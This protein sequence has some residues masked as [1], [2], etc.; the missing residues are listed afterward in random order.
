MSR[1]RA[2]AGPGSIDVDNFAAQ[3]NV[4]GNT[5]PAMLGDGFPDALSNGHESALLEG[6]IQDIF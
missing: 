1:R 2:F 3:K 5:E 6:K 4:G